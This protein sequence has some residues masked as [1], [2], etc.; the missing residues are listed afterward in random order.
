M[1][2][3][4]SRPV[5][6]VAVNLSFMLLPTPELFA[7]P[8]SLFRALPHNSL[9][10]MLSPK[11]TANSCDLSIGIRWRPPR[12]GLSPVAARQAVV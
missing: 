2:S 12:A 3:W 6:Q 9:T 1:L 5:L 8:N 11:N 10:S 7:P 4:V